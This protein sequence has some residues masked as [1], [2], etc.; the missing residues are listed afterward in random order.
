MVGFNGDTYGD[1]DGCDGYGD[2]GDANG[3]M[4]KR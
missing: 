4:V 2:A 3:H 1:G